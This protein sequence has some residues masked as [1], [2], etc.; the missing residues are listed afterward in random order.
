MP[1]VRVNMSINH[2]NICIKAVF[3]SVNRVFMSINR[4]FIRVKPVFIDVNRVYVLLKILDK[5]GCVIV[6]Y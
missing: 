5:R 6:P 1:I 3:M 2:K 4:Q